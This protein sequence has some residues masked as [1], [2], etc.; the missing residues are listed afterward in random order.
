MRLQAWLSFFSLRR[1]HLR[2]PLPS[3]DF[4]G[5]VLGYL[6]GNIPRAQTYVRLQGQLLYI[7]VPSLPSSPGRLQFPRPCGYGVSVGGT[8]VA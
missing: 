1:T 3:P 5:H 2:D 6:I 8:N 4:S 7:I